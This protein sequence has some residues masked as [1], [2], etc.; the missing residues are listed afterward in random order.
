MSQQGSHVRAKVDAGVWNRPS[1]DTRSWA[2]ISKTIEM[3]Y[4]SFAADA[5]IDP[6]L[7]WAKG[8]GRLHGSMCKVLFMGLMHCS[9]SG[10]AIII[11]NSDADERGSDGKAFFKIA[12]VIVPSAQRPAFDRLMFPSISSIKAMNFDGLVDQTAARKANVTRWKTLQ[13]QWETAGFNETVVGGDVIFTYN[14]ETFY[15]QRL[16]QSSCRKRKLD[17]ISL[18]AGE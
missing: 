8:G 10:I 2:T 5:G 13:K 6:V 18:N 7:P 15:K 17:E 9:V 11:Y 1:D 4:P 12:R 16:Q 3:L 14:P